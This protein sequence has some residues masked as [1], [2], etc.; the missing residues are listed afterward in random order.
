MDIHIYIYIYYINQLVTGRPHLNWYLK[1]LAMK[2]GGALSSQRWLSQ[3]PAW[4]QIPQSHWV[5]AH[6]RNRKWVPPV[7]NWPIL[8]LT[9]PFSLGLQRRKA[10]RW[11]FASV[12]TIEVPDHLEGRRKRGWPQEN[13]R[14]A[15]WQHFV[16]RCRFVWLLFLCDHKP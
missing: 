2:I 7:I 14:Q 15:Q 1:K 6:H 4:L 5:L 10:W 11:W 13:G 3:H 9:T 8:T 12:A 16:A